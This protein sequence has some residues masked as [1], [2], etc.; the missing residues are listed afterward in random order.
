MI[1]L[2]QGLLQDCDRDLQ[3]KVLLEW[4]QRLQKA[5]LAYEQELGAAS[6]LVRQ[7][8]QANV[9][10]LREHLALLRQHAQIGL[11]VQLQHLKRRDHVNP[12]GPS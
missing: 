10:L 5:C 6:E 1:Q 11:D 12:T 7:Q 2:L 3:H 4:V 9:A 8:G